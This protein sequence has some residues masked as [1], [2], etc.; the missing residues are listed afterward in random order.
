MRG[1]PVGTLCVLTQTKLGK[2]VGAVVRIISPPW[3]CVHWVQDVECL[4][5]IVGRPLM[6]PFHRIDWMKPLEDPDAK[7]QTKEREIAQ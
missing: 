6:T 3:E 7:E 2:N 1:Y 5:P 4:T